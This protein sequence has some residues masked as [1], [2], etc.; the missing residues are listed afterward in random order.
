MHLCATNNWRQIDCVDSVSM[1]EKSVE[2]SWDKQ[3]QK[4]IMTLAIL[5]LSVELTDFSNTPNANTRL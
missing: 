5:E 1:C 3:L 2:T 4:I